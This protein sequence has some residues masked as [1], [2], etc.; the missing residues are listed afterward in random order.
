[1]RI[2]IEDRNVGVGRVLTDS[3]GGFVEA[4]LTVADAAVVSLSYAAAD[5]EPLERCMKTLGAVLPGRPVADLFQMN[6]NVI[7][8]NIEPELTRSELVNASYAVIAVKRAAADWC[9][10]NGVDYDP[11]VCGCNCMDER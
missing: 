4:M 11:S 3:P 9:R 1:M 2:D 8:Y 5:N 10:K 7:Y 6:N